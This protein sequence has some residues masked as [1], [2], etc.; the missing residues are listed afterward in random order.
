MSLQDYKEPPTNVWIEVYDHQEK[1][2]IRKW[3][4]FGSIGPIPAVGDTFKVP[5]EEFPHID[6]GPSYIVQ[7]REFLIET[8]SITARIYGR[9]QTLG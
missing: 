1:P 2:L 4:G 6:Q 5:N 7:R 8:G 9:D 3:L